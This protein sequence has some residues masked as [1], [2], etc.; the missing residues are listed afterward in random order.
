M[1]VDDRGFW[2]CWIENG[3]VFV[4]FEEIVFD[5]SFGVV[6]YRYGIGFCGVLKCIRDECIFFNEGIF[7]CDLYVL[8]EWF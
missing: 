8:V 7:V 5:D 3:I 2:G 6:C 4:V 1:V